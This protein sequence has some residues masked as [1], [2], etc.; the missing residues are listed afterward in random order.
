MKL[1][2]YQQ[3]GT[4]QGS[5]PS[6]YRESLIWCLNFKMHFPSLI[7][8]LFVFQIFSYI[9][10]FPK[11]KGF[12]VEIPYVSKCHLIFI[13]PPRLQVLEYDFTY[14]SIIQFGMHMCN[15][16]TKDSVISPEALHHLMSPNSP[17]SYIILDQVANVYSFPSF[18][19]FT[20]G[21]KT[22]EVI[23]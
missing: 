6:W 12:Q 14:I 5:L 21:A 7:H 18:N 13:D 9:K 22:T 17:I 4:V 16:F 8:L 10:I 15:F 11:Q 3:G 23:S 19:F 1:P 20:V 2:W